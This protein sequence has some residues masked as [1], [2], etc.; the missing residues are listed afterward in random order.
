MADRE[1]QK[2]VRNPRHRDTDLEKIANN[3]PNS[4]Q[5]NGIEEEVKQEEKQNAE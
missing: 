3:T 1:P 2:F 5:F 4:D